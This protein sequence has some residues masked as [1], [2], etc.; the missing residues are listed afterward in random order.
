MNYRI[1]HTSIKRQRQTSLIS[2]KLLKVNSELTLTFINI[3]QEVQ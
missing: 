3:F 2:T 1:Q